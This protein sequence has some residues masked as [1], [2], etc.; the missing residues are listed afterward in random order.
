M[1]NLLRS[2]ASARKSLPTGVVLDRRYR[3]E[4]LLGRGGMGYV[5]RVFDTAREEVVALKQ[6]APAHTDSGQAATTG[7][8]RAASGR[9]LREVRRRIALFQREYHTLAELAHTNIIS[10]YDY[11]IHA[12]TPYYTM[13][14]LKGGDVGSQTP[15]D[16]HSACAV[17][18]DVAS[19]LTRLHARRLLHRDVSPS[20]VHRGE[21]GTCKLIDFGAM[22]AMGSP[23]N[24]VGTAPFIA[25][26]ALRQLPLDARADLYSLGALGYY[27]LS[28]QTVHAVRT[29]DDAFN[30]LGHRP[31]PISEQVALPAAVAELVMRLVSPEPAARPQ[32]AVEVVEHLCALAGLEHKGVNDVARA[33]VANTSLV[34]R[35]LAIQGMRRRGRRASRGQ[36]AS[37]LLP[38]ARGSGRTR[39]LDACALQAKLMGALVVRC[40]AATLD[41]RPLSA[42][43]RLLEVLHGALGREE[44]AQH[45]LTDVLSR[46]FFAGREFRAPPSASS[47]GLETLEPPALA[48]LRVALVEFLTAVT[49][50]RFVMIAVDNAEHLDAD[51]AEVLLSLAKRATSCKLL[52][53]V[54]LDS[55][56]RPPAKAALDALA[57]ESTG[58]ALAPL[59]L[60]ESGRL[61]ASVFGD[62]PNLAVVNHRIHALS[63]G[64]PR[65]TVE[66][67][68]HLIDVGAIRYESGGYVLPDALL[69]QQLPETLGEALRARVRRL[70]PEARALCTVLALAEGMPLSARESC[71]LAGLSPET[72]ERAL[73]ELTASCIAQELGER[74]SL[75]QTALVEPLA[76]E[77]DEAER[78]VLHERIAALAEADPLRQV[79]AAEHYFGAGQPLRAI[80]RLLSAIADEAIGRA[81]H[82]NL[83]RLVDRAVTACAQ[84]GRPAAQAFAL[85]CALAQQILSFNEP[86]ESELLL[87]ISHDLWRLSGL[88]DWHELW[89]IDDPKARL[90][91]AL[92]RAQERFEQ[93]PERERILPP[94]EAIKRLVSYHLM[95]VGFASSTLHME[96]LHG[97]PSMAP[98]APLS[99]A[100]E[101]LE[102]L[103]HALRGLRA[104]FTERYLEGMEHVLRRLA[105]ADEGASRSATR[106]AFASTSCM[107][108]RS[109]KDRSGAQS[110]STTRRRWK[111]IRAT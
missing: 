97:L 40:D 28:G 62:V 48:P 12:G 29:L 18:R 39:L 31:R 89:T 6:L 59:T 87:S 98:Y 34:G 20:N 63:A 68:Q 88:R 2:G 42:F 50:T 32:S 25:P 19:A 70:S 33:Y 75:R 109:P 43:R 15:L 3:V 13:E 72:S 94:G 10:A 57:A 23:K 96:V 8:I 49:Q 61:L 85:R 111:S 66:L 55:E 78:T 45:V 103:V 52:M 67:A 60:A 24:I 44:R 90:R 35:R 71:L 95:L 105:D 73:R 104:G 51:S 99:S 7:S 84:F 9:G 92:A 80:D 106:E 82:P 53:V 65:L 102:V 86:C 30:A 1:A 74:V 17:L 81:W 64:A 107:A 14:L 54:A 16:W 91:E 26:E 4:G 11:G 76:C 101:V 41:G 5:Y 83:Q 46:A 21:D 110:P 38:G 108:S 22:A 58:F 56:A 100:I 47:L 69:P 93:T 36:S 37:V 27:L 77:L 79:H